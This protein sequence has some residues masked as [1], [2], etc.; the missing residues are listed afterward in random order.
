MNSLQ[1]VIKSF[2]ESEIKQLKKYIS[3][4]SDIKHRKDIQ[5]LMLL[6]TDKKIDSKEVAERIYSSYN[7]N[8]YHQLRKTLYNHIEDFICQLNVLHDE[9][10]DIISY[11]ILARYLFS[12]KLS[13]QGWKYL[14]KAERVSI[15]SEQFDLL[16]HVY[17]LQLDNTY[18]KYSPEINN[19][20]K[21]KEKNALLAEQDG[22]M[23]IVLNLLKWD[24]RKSET[25]SSNYNIDQKFNEYSK[26]F[27]LK[28]SIKNIPKLE[29][30]TILLITRVM[31]E[32]REYEELVSFIKPRY[33]KLLNENI[34]SRHT[35]LYKIRMIELLCRT[36]LKLRKYKIAE[37]Y[38]HELS[39]E[40][41]K[42]DRQN[43]NLII[44]SAPLFSDIMNCTNRKSEGIQFLENILNN[45]PYSLSETDEIV[46]KIN[47]AGLYYETKNY[48]DVIKALVPIQTKEKLITSQFGIN[49]SMK[50]QLMECI[51]YI[52]HNENTLAHS[53]IRSIKRKYSDLL[54][55][56]EFKRENMFISLVSEINNDTTIVNQKKFIQKINS[57]LKLKEVSPGDIEI[58]SFNAWLKSKIDKKEYYEVFLEMIA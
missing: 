34:F 4:K 51:I 13:K 57:F 33:M 26:R 22:T 27:D 14:I 44:P 11:L 41:L 24:L 40:L 38:F 6:R 47:L 17:Y 16:N 1:Q 21:K 55:L 46:L 35:H 32:K 54:K 15:D 52:D 49:A 19:I 30:S 48:Q 23:N 58:I 56:K 37:K 29:Y 50:I 42:Y 31:F 10:F 45:P 9:T 3:R 36:H 12:K 20:I 7:K 25:P 18:H 53:R 8:A 28:F 39:D 43:Y 2:S 5:L